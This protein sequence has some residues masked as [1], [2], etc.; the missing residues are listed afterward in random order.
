MKDVTE[1]VDLPDPLVRPLVHPLDVPAARGPFRTALLI[2]ML[3]SPAVGLCIAVVIWFTSQSFVVPL[4][5]GAAIIGLGAMANRFFRTE[6][7]AFIPRK[8]QDLQRRLPLAWEFGSG[9]VLAAVLTLALLLVSFRLH[10]ADVGVG[11]REVTFGMGS[12]VAL[13][14]LFDC[15]RRVRAD[16]G[17]DIGRVL[18]ALPALAAIIGGTA[19]AYVVLF[20]A[21]RPD[22]SSTLL[23]SAV[24]MIVVGGA[25]G[26][27]MRLEGGLTR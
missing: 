16:R 18:F 6:A 24:A 25:A 15:F 26:A 9:L 11:V 21:S 2:G 12:A 5:A 3:T 1:L 10:Q 27:W 4:V 22:S 13:L 19:T 14:V 7:W 20:G 17:V 8:R 23:L